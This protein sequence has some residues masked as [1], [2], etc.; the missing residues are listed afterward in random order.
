MTSTE[1][2]EMRENGM[3]VLSKVCDSPSARKK[4]E[5]RLFLLV[6]DKENMEELYKRY[7]IQLVG[8][9]IQEPNS[10]KIFNKLLKL[11]RMGWKNP[12]YTCYQNNIDEHDNF[13]VHPFDVVDG[14]V[15]CPKCHKSKTW[16]VQKQTRSADEPMTTFSKCADPDCG[17]EWTYSG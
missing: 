14:V 12:Q 6:K 1:I 3:K 16:S 8:M 10:T 15:E 5:K 7:L 9:L 13:I 4:M 11:G 17:H 2:D